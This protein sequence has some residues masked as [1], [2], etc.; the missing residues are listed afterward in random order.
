MGEHIIT[1]ND[2]ILLLGLVSGFFALYKIKKEIVHTINK[3]AEEE[4]RWMTTVELTLKNLEEN[5]KHIKNQTNDI[6]KQIN[7]LDK[8]VLVLKQ[9]KQT[10][11]T[12]GKAT[13]GA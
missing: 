10:S 7:T 1:I 8:E 13:K 6:I 12:R 11:Q 5:F 3:N 4:A 2:I 9:I